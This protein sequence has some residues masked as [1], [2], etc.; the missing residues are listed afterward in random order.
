MITREMLDELQTGMSKE[1]VRFLLG[2]P[3]LVD[4]FH[5]DRWDYI[6]WLKKPDSAAVENRSVADFRGWHAGPR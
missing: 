1:Q 5:Q 6:Y 2:T 3:A 4:V